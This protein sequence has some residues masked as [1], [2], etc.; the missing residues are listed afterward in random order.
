[1]NTTSLLQDIIGRTKVHAG[2]C[3]QVHFGKMQLI[4]TN[5]LSKRIHESKSIAKVS[6][7]IQR[8]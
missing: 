5:S 4:K 7:L 3:V 8:Y 6:I 2:I 1:M